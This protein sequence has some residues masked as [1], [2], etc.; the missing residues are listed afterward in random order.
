MGEAAG[1]APGHPRDLETVRRYKS[2][3]SYLFLL[4]HGA[5][6]IEYPATGTDLISGERAD[7]RVRVRPGGV[8]V[9]EEER[10]KRP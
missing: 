4:N 9:L 3:K 10:G 1:V 6:E 8:R 7:G 5:T 2:G